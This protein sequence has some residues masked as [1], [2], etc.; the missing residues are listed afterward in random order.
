MNAAE[1]EPASG[2]DKA[3]LRCA[4]HLVLDG[5][6]ARRAALGA[7]EA[8]SRWPSR[9]RGASGRVVAAALQERRDP[10]RWQLASVPDGFVA[11]EETALVNAP[12]RRAGKPAFKP[13]QPFERGVGGA[14]T[15][16]QNAETLAH[17]ALIARFGG[18][19]FRE[20]GTRR[21]ARHGARHARRAPSR[22]PAST[23]SSS[24]RRSRSCSR[25]RAA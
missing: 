7:R 20:L 16:V 13:P 17:L 8:S 4:P 10:L 18:E 3:L 2:K 6:A 9:R 21:R 1:G 14:P 11:G 15:L 25:R 5:A 22:G 24:A 12:E 23:R 19:W